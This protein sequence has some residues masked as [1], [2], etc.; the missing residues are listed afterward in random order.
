[1]KPAAKL[2]LEVHVMARSDNESRYCCESIF[3]AIVPRLQKAQLDTTMRPRSC[4][5]PYKVA[6][7]QSLTPKQLR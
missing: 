1:M 7:S 6:A 3:H 2:L 5:S 4:L